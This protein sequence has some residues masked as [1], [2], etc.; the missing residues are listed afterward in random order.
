MDWRSEVSRWSNAVEPFLERKKRRLFRK[1]PDPKPHLD[2]GPPA[3]PENLEQLQTDVGLQI[4]D[5]LREF[6]L[7]QTGH[8]EFWWNLDPDSMPLGSDEG[9]SWGYIE[10]NPESMRNLN[11]DRTGFLYE[12]NPRIEN[13]WSNTFRF[14]GVP[15]GDSIGI[16]T[17][18][19]PEPGRV[20]YLNHEEPEKVIRLAGSFTEFMTAWLSLGCVGPEIDD[21]LHF[22]DHGQTR[23]PRSLREANDSRLDPN[24]PNALQFRAFFGIS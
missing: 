8:L 13:L 14:L 11:S 7:T 17:N 15:N 24:C 6:L 18:S 23:I 20:V 19:E 3:S 10:F 21:L 4:P 16:D 1:E 5:Q 9:P 22:L 2:V 12:E